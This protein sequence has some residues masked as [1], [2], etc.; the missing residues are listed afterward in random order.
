MAIRKNNAKKGAKKTVNDTMK[1]LLHSTLL[2]YIVFIIAIVEIMC[3]FAKRDNESIFL[4]IILAFIVYMHE[5]NMI[6]VLGVPVV[7]VS[8]L[9][10]LRRIFR[11]SQNEGFEGQELEVFKEWAINYTTEN[12]V[13]VLDFEEDISGYGSLY[14]KT[15]YIFD[16]E[17][18]NDDA[19]AEE[20]LSF[21]EDVTNDETLKGDQVDFI[22]EMFEDYQTILKE[23]KTEKE[24]EEEEESESIQELI[25]ENTLSNKSS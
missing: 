23:K 12:E 7:V 1:S 10:F 24:D 2:L 16:E 17:T 19:P 9:V 4:F 3:L 22:K 8:L 15:L 25:P 11:K 20:L 6:V 5:K 18:K 21:L 13:L 14:K